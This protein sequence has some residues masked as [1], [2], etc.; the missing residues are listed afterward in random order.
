MVGLLMILLKNS[1]LMLHTNLLVAYY[2]SSMLLM[3]CVRMTPVI[4]LQPRVLIV[5]LS[6]FKF[7][8]AKT[9]LNLVDLFSRSP[10]L[11]KTFHPITN[12][13]RLRVPVIL[14]TPYNVDSTTY[15]NTP[16]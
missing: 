12:Q 15:K 6:Y 9:L 7:G 4:T 13:G 2:T 10:E 14:Q 1:E 8:G 11:I 16:H 5:H 3:T